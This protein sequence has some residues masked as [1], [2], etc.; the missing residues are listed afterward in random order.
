MGEHLLWTSRATT[1][2]FARLVLAEAGIAHATRFVSLREGEHRQSEFLAINPKGQV[3]TLVL[4][5]GTVLTE[6][7][8]IALWAGQAAPRSGLI[9]PDPLGAARTVE[10]LSWAVCTIVSAWQPAFLPARFTDGGEAAE[11]AVASRSRARAA[12]A[13]AIPEQALA[14]RDTLQGGAPTAADLMLMF[15]TTVAD[16]VGLLGQR[17][18]LSA[19]RARLA[20]RPAVAAVLA[21]EGL[22]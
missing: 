21:D 8:A 1:G 2:T 7:I 6:N 13:L 22:A 4:A 9:P 19:H 18:N 17:P 20:A 5:D 11:A 14:G 12:E 15:M 3:P 10:W 16:R